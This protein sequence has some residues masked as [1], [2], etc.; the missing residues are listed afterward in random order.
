MAAGRMDQTIVIREPN[1]TKTESG[2]T[3]IEYTDSE[4]VWAH[5][6]YADS[7][8]DGLVDDVQVRD[9]L[10]IRVRIRYNPDIATEWL[11]RYR[12]RDW[13]VISVQHMGIRDETHLRCRTGIVKN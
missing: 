5:V 3:K 4:P 8:L 1:P 6:E 10:N 7:V 13:N 11:V 12:E 2:F 9:A